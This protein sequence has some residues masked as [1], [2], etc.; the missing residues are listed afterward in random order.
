[1]REIGAP[2]Y[3]GKEERVERLKTYRDYK[4]VPLVS[5]GAGAYLTAASRY[6]QQF[7]IERMIIAEENRQQRGLSRDEIVALV[8]EWQARE[9]S[10]AAYKLLFCPCV[11]EPRVVAFRLPTVIDARLSPL[12]AA[13]IGFVGAALTVVRLRAVGKSV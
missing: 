2:V 10:K 13:C 1:M 3:P 5:S 8:D 12:I 6:V 4:G 7:E 9:I 11:G